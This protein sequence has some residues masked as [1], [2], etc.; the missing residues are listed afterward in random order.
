MFLF[1][2]EK[3]PPFPV[4]HDAQLKVSVLFYIVDFCFTEFH[5]GQVDTRPVEHTGLQGSKDQCAGFIW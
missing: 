1:Q 5:F 4:F 3:Y 2:S